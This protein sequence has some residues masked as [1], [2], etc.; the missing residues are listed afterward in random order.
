M[1]S[2]AVAAGKL[3][4]V[5][6][7]AS[8]SPFR[9][10][11]SILNFAVY[12]RGVA[13]ENHDG[14]DVSSRTEYKRLVASPVTVATEAADATDAAI[15]LKVAGEKCVEI[16]DWADMWT[17]YAGRVEVMLMLLYNTVACNVDMPKLGKSDSVVGWNVPYHVNQE[18][19]IVLVACVAA[20]EILSQ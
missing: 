12:S 7:V 5:E 18:A 3:L 10:V 9:L 2:G 14:R 19:G 8:L 13:E 1:T 20:C 6:T 17:K 15:S 4:V 16:R 11:S